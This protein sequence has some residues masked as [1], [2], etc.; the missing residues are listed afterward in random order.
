MRGMP[1]EESRELYIAALEYTY[2]DGLMADPM[3][4]EGRSSVRRLG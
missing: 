2:D 1:D 3:Y 4:L